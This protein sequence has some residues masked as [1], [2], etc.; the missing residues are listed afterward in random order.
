MVAPRLI[1]TMYVF[2]DVELSLAAPLGEL[3]VGA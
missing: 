2:G 1:V 3:Q